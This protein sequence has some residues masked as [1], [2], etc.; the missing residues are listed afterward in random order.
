[1]A[2]DVTSYEQPKASMSHTPSY[3]DTL[4]PK[5]SKVT[6]L[7]GKQRQDTATTRTS[8][9]IVWFS[10]VDMSLGSCAHNDAIKWGTMHHNII[11]PPSSTTVKD[12]VELSLIYHITSEPVSNK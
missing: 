7:G 1:M 6:P 3:L 10:P 9:P 4:D 8:R 11:A 2:S 5:D 12:H